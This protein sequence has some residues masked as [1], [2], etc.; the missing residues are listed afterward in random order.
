MA[1]FAPARGLYSG[2]GFVE[3]PPFGSYRLDPNCVFMTFELRGE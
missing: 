2:F 3:C 1:A